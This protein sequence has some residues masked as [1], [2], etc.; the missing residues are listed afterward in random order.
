[1]IDG[2]A[3]V[4]R[5]LLRAKIHGLTVTDA[6]LDYEGSLTI[7]PELLAASE[8][9]EYE[10]IA[11]WNVTRGTRFETYAIVG[12]PGSTDICVNGA[13]AH[14]A[15]TGDKIIVAAFALVDEAKVAEFIQAVPDRTVFVDHHNRKTATR[16]EIPGPQVGQSTIF[17]S[18][19]IPN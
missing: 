9:A 2:T 10:A 3:G 8:I 1:M 11:V 5:K 6:N 4:Y 7:S 12:L 17:P 18:G 14:L 15:K 19:N 13:A 16:R